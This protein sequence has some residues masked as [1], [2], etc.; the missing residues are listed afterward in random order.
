MDRQRGGLE[1]ELTEM[2]KTRMQ[3][4]TGLFYGCFR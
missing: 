4:H 1:L 3:A 2:V